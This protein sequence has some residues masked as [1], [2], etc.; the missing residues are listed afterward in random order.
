M[1][2]MVTLRRRRRPGSGGGVREPVIGTV[3]VLGGD[4]GVVTEGEHCSHRASA[5]PL[6]GSG[7]RHAPTPQPARHTAS[8]ASAMSVLPRRRGERASGAI[9]MRQ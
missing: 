3:S 5:E 2:P 6:A 8:P 4:T 1:S 7:E 9:N